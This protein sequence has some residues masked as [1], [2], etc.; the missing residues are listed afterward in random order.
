[1]S[2]FNCLLVSDNWVLLPLSSIFIFDF[3]LALLK[4]VPPGFFDESY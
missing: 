1:M 3:D 2:Q 4:N